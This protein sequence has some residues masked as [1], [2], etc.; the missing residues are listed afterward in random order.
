MHELSVCQAVIAQVEQIARQ[1]DARVA[2][3]TVRI[4]SLSGVESALLQRAY[5]LAVA[6]TALSRARLVIDVAPVRVRCRS[7]F[8]ETIV[9]PNRLLCGVCGEWR[10]DLV[11]GDELL[12]ASVELERNQHV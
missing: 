12:L 6:G 3:I 10:T 1:H 4:G 9:E 8:A 11:S 2:S 5:P 7:C